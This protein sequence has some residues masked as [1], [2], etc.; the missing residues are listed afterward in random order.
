MDI[1]PTDVKRL[2]GQYR[3][4]N[5]FLKWFVDKYYIKPG[6][7]YGGDINVEDK[8]NE[9]LQIN[10]LKSRLNQVDT[11]PESYDLVFEMDNSDII[12]LN[13][14]KQFMLLIIPDYF[15]RIRAERNLNNHRLNYEL[16]NINR[17]LRQSQILLRIVGSYGGVKTELP[18][19]AEIYLYDGK[20]EIDLG[21][22]IY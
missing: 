14:I 13:I 7:K 6:N 15:N 3:P 20:N 16:N 8:F 5:Q 12:D 4:E 11:S 22:E 18:T 1:L 19:P 9:L 17:H 21:L 10:N 2:I